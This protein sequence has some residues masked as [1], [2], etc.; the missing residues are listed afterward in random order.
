MNGKQCSCSFA[1]EVNL[2][3]ITPAT[4][5]QP[6]QD[7]QRVI[8]S[9]VYDVSVGFCDELDDVMNGSWGSNITW[10][11]SIVY[12]T[13][14]DGYSLNGNRTLQ[15]VPGLSPYYPI[16][17]SS[18]PTC[19]MLKDTSTSSASD[20]LYPDENLDNDSK[21]NTRGVYY[22]F[23]LFI[24]IIG[25]ILL[26]V[27]RMTRDGKKSSPRT[28]R[29]RQIHKQS[30]AP[31]ITA[32]GES[33]LTNR[34]RALTQPPIEESLPTI[35]LKRSQH[36]TQMPQNVNTSS[37][38]LPSLEYSDLQQT[39]QISHTTLDMTRPIQRGNA[40][41]RPAAS[42][43]ILARSQEVAVGWVTIRTDS[44][45]YETIPDVTIAGPSKRTEGEQ[46]T[47]E[48][49]VGYINHNPQPNWNKLATA[50]GA[51]DP[52][53]YPQAQVQRQHELDAGGYLV[54]NVL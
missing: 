11:G 43:R 42:A 45:L 54:P 25:V 1:D 17:N 36:V 9:L 31:S 13:C 37:T 44:V 41:V 7:T 47:E 10:F 8:N 50:D 20:T 16:W 5:N 40:D 2:S 18:L 49:A 28:R 21:K 3:D 35:L 46:N 6:T 14:D 51:W 22:L 33:D 15:C 38:L 52:L 23:F 53:R 32:T 24:P 48:G 27:L 29:R 4:C 39:H 34:T 19:D 26:A 30:E 12:L